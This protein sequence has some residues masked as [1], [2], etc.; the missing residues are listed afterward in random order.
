[1]RSL[2]VLRAK[3]CY[4]NVRGVYSILQV[5]AQQRTLLAF[6]GGP[7]WAPHHRGGRRVLLSASLPATPVA[8]DCSFKSRPAGR[9]VPCRRSGRGPQ[10][11]DAPGRTAN[12][13][14]PGGLLCVLG[15]PSQ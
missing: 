15:W 8:L 1:M 4:L 10:A 14:A 6:S 2:N 3:A 9:G 7:R 13:H 11:G 12:S 5:Y